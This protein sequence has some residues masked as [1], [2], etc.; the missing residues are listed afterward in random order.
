[1]PRIFLR[2]FVWLILF[3][4]AASAAWSQSNTTNSN[5][6][7]NYYQSAAGLSCAELKTALFQIISSNTTTL[8]YNDLWTE[9][10]RTDRRRNDQNTADIVWDMYS[11]NP[12]G[13]E[14]YTFTFFVNQCGNYSK[15]GDCY[16]R[17]HSFP[18]SWFGGSVLP[19]YSDMH[20]I[21]P[22]DGFVNNSR[23]NDPLG[24]VG[25]ASRVSL[26]G[27]KVGTSNFPGYTGRVFE[28]IN[29][30]KGDLA[31]AQLYM[32]VRYESQIAGWRTNSNADEVLNGTS[33]QVF[34]PWHLRLLYKWH[35]Q[36]PVSQ[37]ERNRNDSIF[38]R[39]GN[40]NPF[41]DNPDWVY[42]I[43][44]CTGLL[45]PT[46]VRNN[47]PVAGMSVYPNP[48]PAGQALQIQFPQGTTG[49]VT[50]QL[51]QLN[52][53]VV[54][55]HVVAA[56]RQQFNINSAALSAGVYL[57]QVITSKSIVT[58]KVVVQ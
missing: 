46:S 25:T 58:Q 20:H 2:Y 27:S 30:Y 29:E 56:G 35:V 34:D 11:D 49:V 10:Y 17:E 48:L 12:N 57:L 21:F 45:T 40:R 39:Q 18:Q 41:I 33:Y 1:M 16:N 50:L 53:T 42:E 26:N 3:V 23:G 38:V 5:L 9:F 24:E 15:E 51:M 22:T 19:M 8:A 55:R 44:K 47:Q 32:A 37:K 36:D 7:A 43:W 54:Q 4:A 13:P 52:G 14:P 31:R 6:P 28:P